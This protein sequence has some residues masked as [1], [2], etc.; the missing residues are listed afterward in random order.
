MI[1]GKYLSMLKEMV[2]QLIR[3]AIIYNPDSAPAAGTFFLTPF[4]DA[5]K[6]FKV[7]ASTSLNVESVAVA[8]VG[9]TST[10][11]NERLPATG[12]RRVTPSKPSKPVSR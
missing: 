12:G 3:V 2:P 7:A 9:S 4:T 11:N 5:A 8:L 1:T 6:E 10:A